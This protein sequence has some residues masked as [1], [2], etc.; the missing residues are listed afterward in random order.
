MNH[1][2]I[3]QMTIPEFILREIDREHEQ[4]EEGAPEKDAL[5]ASLHR[6][7]F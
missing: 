2:I 3:A 1:S 4:K 6:N 5:N 7:Y